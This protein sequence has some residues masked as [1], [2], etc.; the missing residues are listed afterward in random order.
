MMFDTAASIL[1]HV[2]GG[3]IRALAIAR[4]ARLPEYP[5]IPTFAEA[6]V[7]GYEANAWYSMHAPAR[8]PLVITAKVHRDLVRVLAMPDIRE[9]LRQLGSEGVGNSPDEFAR[10]V[11]AEADKYSKLIREAG[12]RVE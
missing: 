4:A 7:R 3:K 11:R 5:D 12:I 10:F 9:K 8:V 2:K 1:P 6:G